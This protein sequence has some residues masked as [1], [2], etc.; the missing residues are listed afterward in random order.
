MYSKVLTRQTGIVLDTIV[1]SQVLEIKRPRAVLTR[2]HLGDV[3]WKKPR[4][5]WCQ[6]V[7]LSDMFVEL[8]EGDPTSIMRENACTISEFLLYVA[9]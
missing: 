6:V 9:R 3:V 7:G 2:Q 4:Q 5:S 1:E 8:Q